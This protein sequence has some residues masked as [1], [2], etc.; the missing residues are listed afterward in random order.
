MG[1]GADDPGLITPAE[2]SLL[3]DQYE[4][5]MAASYLKRGR[6]VQA[7]RWPATPPDR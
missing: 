1:F 4:L 2:T 3:T 5:A 7:R 6:A